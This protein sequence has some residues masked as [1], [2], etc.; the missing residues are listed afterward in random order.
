[1]SHHVSHHREALPWWFFAIVG[2]VLT[3]WLAP[4][5]LAGHFG[6]PQAH[7]EEDEIDDI[8]TWITWTIVL[9]YAIPGGVVGAVLGLLIIRPVNVG[10]AW[11]FRGFNRVFDK[12]TAFYGALVGKILRMSVI[13]LIV[14]GGL[15]VLTYWEFIRTPTGFIPQQDK[16]YLI[17]NVQLPD[18]AS[19]ERTQEVMNLVQRIALGDKKLRRGTAEAQPA[20]GAPQYEGVA[21]ISHTLAISGQS[22]IMSAN[23]P[24]LGSM[25]IMLKPFDRRAGS[26]LTADAIAARLQ[27]I[28][29]REVPEALVT[30]FGAPPVDGLGTTG[31]FNLIVEDRG[32]QGLD[33]LEKVSNDIVFEGNKTPGLQGL[34]NSS[35]A[36]TP[37]LFLDIDRDKC[38]SEGHQYT[39]V[40]N[41]LQIYLGSYYVNN[42]NEFG[43]TWQVNIQADPKFRG[44]IEQVLQ[45]QI[46]NNKG[47][48]VR[49]N[50]FVRV[51]DVSGPVVVM[52]YNMYTAASI[53]GNPAP[54]TGSQQAVDQMQQ[55]ATA[56]LP[57][58][59]QTDW[60]ELAYLQNQAGNSA[61]WFFGLAVIFVFLVLAAQYESW[62]LP[63]AV[64]LVV[65]MCLL[66]SVVGVNL[67]GIEVSIFTQIG[68]VVLVGLASKNAILIVEFAKQQEESG[69]SRWEATVQAVKLRLRPILMTSFAFILGVVP[70]VIATGAGSEMRRSLGIAVFAGMLGVTVFGVF[71]T[72]VFYYVIQWFGSRHGTQVHRHDER[73]GPSSPSP[74]NGH[75]AKDFALAGSSAGHEQA[76][77][78]LDA[79]EQSDS[80]DVDDL[81]KALAD[82]AGGPLL[83]DAAKS[84]L[85]RRNR[86]AKH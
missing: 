48:M 61:M 19:V 53:T 5:L 52:R 27:E 73:A 31:G 71:L 36:N 77:L 55:I 41:A 74:R 14:Y 40:F 11:F 4:K 76:V 65:P 34:F 63:L 82:G 18:S 58:A 78:A 9:A 75:G 2:A 3:A 59:M 81:L 66:C 60:T 25:Y 32:N 20:D 1:M 24:N 15:L 7:G 22:I 42:F 16:G 39:D 45:Y 83:A 62:S 46:K 30:V 54:G 44:T 68:F 49:L 72:P 28:C 56:K 35:G 57:H 29:R 67:A 21:G 50:T 10:L 23:A 8:P 12:M 47:G 70:L 80:Q 84:A 69:V 26:N 6:L 13:V 64:I 43:R 38:S 85:E 86:A 17:V 37:W 51:R 33:A 79:L